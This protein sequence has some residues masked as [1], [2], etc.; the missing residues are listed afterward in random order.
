VSPQPGSA[1]ALLRWLRSRTPTQVSVAGLVLLA[2]ASLAPDFRSSVIPRHDARQTLSALHVLASGLR[3]ESE[4]PRWQ[5]YGRYGS[6]SFILLLCVTPAAHAVAIASTLFPPVSAIV[7]LKIVTLVEVLI[8][9]AG[10]IR[11]TLLLFRSMAA[12]ALVNAGAILSFS[13]LSSLDADLHYFYMLPLILDALIRF[14]REGRFTSLL[15]AVLYCI[16]SAVGN[17]YYYP[18]I[19]AL[20]LTVFCATLFWARGFHLPRVRF[21]RVDLLLV[22]PIVVLA[23]AQTAGYISSFHDQHTYTPGRDPETSRVL[24]HFFV[25]YDGVTTVPNLVKVFVTGAQTHGDAT[26]YIG[27]APLVLA[28]I[29]LVSCRRSEFISVAVTAGFLL[30]FTFGGFVAQ[31]T[32]WFPGMSYFRHIFMVFGQVRYLLLLMAGFGL[33]ALLSSTETGGE[34][35]IRRRGGRILLAAAGL[36]TTAELVWSLARTPH[37]W[38]FLMLPETLDLPGRAW[39]LP[40]LRAGTYV[41][42]L[43]FS[44]KT[45]RLQ[46]AH[47]LL[48][49]FLI[50]VGSFKTVQF[51][52]WP[53]A[54]PQE[55]AL[56]REVYTPRSPA[57]QPLRTSSDEEQQRSPAFRFA[58][59]EGVNSC[60]YTH[61]YAVLGVDPRIP[62]FRVDTLSVGVD[63]LFR[64]R[65]VEFR[66]LPADN[67]LPPQDLWLRDALGARL[68]KLRVVSASDIDFAPHDP[69]AAVRAL[70]SDSAR[71]VVEAAG[72][73]AASGRSTGSARVA[74]F[75]ANRVEIEA[76]VDGPD[77]AW[78][79]YA[80]SY[81]P[82]WTAT[83]DR[84]AVPIARANLAFKALPLHPGVNQ[85]E[86]RCGNGW[87]SLCLPILS[88]GS[89]LFMIGLAIGVAKLLRTPG[90]AGT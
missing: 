42:L 48:A 60:I 53:P 5:P 19:M 80:D 77:P 64:M 75:G 87:S 1:G 15:L 56:S 6:S 82:A 4:I 23:S 79:Y 8:L 26:F 73:P 90:A 54:S 13:W 76:V 35:Q 2:L 40:L 52:A 83:V 25:G 31:A 18:P 24:L 30:L 62:T 33:E 65:G 50:D 59:E 85:V 10:S 14:S 67:L 70:P 11:L 63:R 43:L 88:G 28:L 17:V 51:F 57:W 55:V 46:P 39:L 41:A 21:S 20:L 27:L 69:A 9:L 45:A 12:I 16:V 81:N 44:V 34:P 7:L 37:A 71:V 36:V 86:L 29:G 68:P 89:V 32:Y 84:T 22:I 49:A 58:V 72:A 78:L 47:A 38:N 66:Q 3:S 74:S 61:V